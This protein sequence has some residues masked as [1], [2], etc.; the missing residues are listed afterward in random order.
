MIEGIN[1]LVSNGIMPIHFDSPPLER[2]TQP[3]IVS[4]QLSAVS[5]QLL[6]E[7]TLIHG[8]A[9]FVYLLYRF[10]TSSKFLV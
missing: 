8:N 1:Q 7:K 9:R 10:I 2:Q 3:S 5:C 6:V 4:C